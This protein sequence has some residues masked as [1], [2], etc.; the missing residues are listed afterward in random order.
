MDDATPMASLS[1][2]V[3]HALK[4]LST[5]YDTYWFC[6][7]VA[8]EVPQYLRMGLWWISRR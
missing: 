6:L 2:L 8:I 1:F 5:P 4:G 7:L 3:L